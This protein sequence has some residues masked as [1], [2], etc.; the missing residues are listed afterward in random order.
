[1]LL[2]RKIP[3]SVRDST[4]FKAIKRLDFLDFENGPWIA[5]GC[6]LGLMRGQKT[7]PS[8]GDIDIFCRDAA[9]AGMVA[10]KLRQINVEGI[11]PGQKFM[12]ETARQQATTEGPPIVLDFHIEG[13][14]QQ[15]E[16]RYVKIQLITF[17][18]FQSVEA[19]FASFDFTVVMM[20]LNG[21]QVGASESTWRDFDNNRLRMNDNQ[22]GGSKFKTLW[23]VSK[24][25]EMGFTPIPGLINEVVGNTMKKLDY[26]PGSMTATWA[27]Y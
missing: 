20:V 2:F 18:S 6:V 19:L 27:T 5:A 26:N 24:Y 16:Q 17:V 22:I 25:C 23:R 15:G 21:D 8:G 7:L 14:G 3:E 4:T 11:Y 13:V 12:V 9:Q 1:M 10:D